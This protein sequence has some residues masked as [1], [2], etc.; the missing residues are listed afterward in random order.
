[1]CILAAGTG[2][3]LRF[4]EG[5]LHKALV[6]IAGRAV[7]SRIIDQ[8]PPDARLVVALGH[9]GDQVAQYLSLAHPGRS[10]RTVSVEP[11]TGPG[12]GP[13][14]S[15]SCC[16]VHLDQPFVLTAVDT[17]AGDIPALGAESWMGVARVPDPERW[18]TL[19]AD[20]GGAVRAL[21]ERVP[22]SPLAFV[23][24]AWI[25]RPDLF[26]SGLAADDAAGG[27]RQVTPGFEALIAGGVTVRAQEV[28]WSDTGSPDTYA[29]TLA[30]HDQSLPERLA[31]DI[32]FLEP[33][34][35]IKWFRDPAAA[36]R[37]ASRG[38]ALDGVVPAVHPAP[39]PWLV[40]DF[41][42]GEP[43]R[44]VDA[45]GVAALLSWA[46]ET[47][48]R[49]APRDDAFAADCRAFHLDKTLGRLGAYLA[50]EGAG[51]EEPEIEIDGRP[52][53]PVADVLAQWID[54]IVADAV[55]STFHGDLHEG[56][57]IRTADG[58]RLI[59]WRDA[60]GSSTVRGDRLYDLA[61]FL[62]TLELPESEMS[63]GTYRVIHTGDRAVRLGHP[64]P[65]GRRDARRRFWAH[66][67]ERGYPERSLGLI[68][69]LVFVNM[70]PLYPGAMGD[71]LYLLGRWLLD[72][73]TTAP[74]GEARDRLFTAGL[75]A[76][77]DARGTSPTGA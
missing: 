77:V 46:E 49:P 48:W 21:R 31:D 28:T 10:I 42:V 15:L 44:G 58:F 61:K 8:F 17:L 2:S 70:A 40:H 59:D 76:G 12:S 68:D 29:R 33:P 55:P 26:L 3:R 16:A 27:E 5:A 36:R 9:L 62:H 69:A 57:V 64:D 11:F 73:S 1:M 23:G 41:A 22:G 63:A 38:E 43:L 37:R 72:I 65:A 14:R 50:R 34:R 20:S 35:V 66:C 4:A 39:E 45:E 13:G 56:N 54:T 74:D 30:S 6:P 51:R 25:T 19:E 7:I 71:Y 60:F 75:A 18:L 67:R 52:T 24:L 47:L 32:T 53:R